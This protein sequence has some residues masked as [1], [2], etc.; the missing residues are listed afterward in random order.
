LAWSCSASDPFTMF[1]MVNNS[2]NSTFELVSYGAYLATSQLLSV[3]A[4]AVQR[5]VG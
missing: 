3:D 2:A 4:N 1:L 5:R